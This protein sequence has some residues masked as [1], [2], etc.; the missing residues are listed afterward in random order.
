M[1]PLANKICLQAFP[2]KGKQKG[3]EHKAQLLRKIVPAVMPFRVTIVL[4]EVAVKEIRGG[5][6]GFGCIF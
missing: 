5:V 3:E 2:K 4:R 6:I 1:L